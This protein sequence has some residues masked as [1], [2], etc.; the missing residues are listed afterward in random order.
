M[1]QLCL[2]PGEEQDEAGLSGGSDPGE[3]WPL[4]TAITREVPAG[5]P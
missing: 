4:T 2:L 5:S 1:A 3:A